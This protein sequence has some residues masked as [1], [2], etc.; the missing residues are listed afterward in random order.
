[1]GFPK[2]GVPSWGPYSEDYS[3]S[4][5]CSGVPCFEKLPFQLDLKG[6]QH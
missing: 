1:M 2:L 5:F 4:V 3:I 6:F